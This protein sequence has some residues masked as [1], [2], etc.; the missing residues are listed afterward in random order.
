MD[1]MAAGKD[2]VFVVDVGLGWG[3]IIYNYI[4]C[5]DGTVF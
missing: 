1:R 3:M 5:P 4:T 2:W